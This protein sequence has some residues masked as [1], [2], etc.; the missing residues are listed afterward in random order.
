[1]NTILKADL[2]KFSMPLQYQEGTEFVSSY[3][4]PRTDFDYVMFMGLQPFLMQIAQN[5]IT[6]DMV[7][8]AQDVVEGARSYFHREGWEYIVKEHG[9]RLPLRVDA[10]PEGTVLNGR[11]VVAQ[12]INTDPNVPWLTTHMET[13]ALRASWYGSSV[14]SYSWATVQIIKKYLEI[15]SDKPSDHEYRLCDFGM[16][17]VSSGE[18]SGIGGCGHMAN[19]KSSD[20]TEAMLFA[21]KFYD[22]KYP[23]VG[24]RGAAEHS[25]ITS[26]GRDREADAYRNMVEKFGGEGRAYA[27]VSDSFDIE[28]A[29]DKI[30]GQDLKELVVQKGGRLIIRPDSEDPVVLVPKLMESLFKNYGG[31]INSKGYSVLPDCVRLI[32]GDGL[33]FAKIVDILETLCDLK[34]ST[35]NIYF[36]MGGTLLQDQLRDDHGWAMKASSTCVNGVWKDFQKEPRGDSNKKS[37]LGRQAVVMEEGA[38]K[39]I[40]EDELG[41][42]ENLLSTVFLNG[43]VIK[44]WTLDEVR[45]RAASFE[46]KID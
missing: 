5:P 3:V 6:M 31:S 4:A 28:N 8:E 30:W 13:A 26:W 27:V 43:E 19:S 14:A 17:S 21:R 15:T 25:T 12:I 40:R 20:N 36:G 10:L 38:Y 46:Y 1:M 24:P 44:K 39:T 22:C 34:I 9:G 37:L 23:V 11:N 33:G 29:V 16:R 7:D 42:R 32:W 35:E 45:A 41:E 18:S 2:Y